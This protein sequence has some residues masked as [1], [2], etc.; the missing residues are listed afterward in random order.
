[1][2]DPIESITHGTV[3]AC[4]H[5]LGELVPMFLRRKQDENQIRIG[6]KIVHSL[7]V[8]GFSG[9]GPTYLYLV[10]VEVSFR[11]MHPV[12]IEALFLKI[13]DETLESTVGD[14]FRSFPF[15]LAKSQCEKFRFCIPSGVII[16]PAEWIV[17]VMSGSRIAASYKMKVRSKETESSY[18]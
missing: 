2:L 9:D 6:A 17:E 13:D 3:L 1:M 10:D 14:P 15:V 7:K 8:N 12:S 4:L 18:V 11:I 5:W 16:L